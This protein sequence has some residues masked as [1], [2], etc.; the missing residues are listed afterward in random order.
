MV[1]LKDGWGY[2]RPVW[3]RVV[4]VILVVIG[5]VIC[6][7]GFWNLKM[8]GRWIV[9]CLQLAASFALLS[10]G[11]IFWGYPVCD[12]VPLPLGIGSHFSAKEAPHG[13]VEL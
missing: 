3:L 6:F 2:Y 12:S 4:G 8:S 7:L 1:L 11:I 5:C 13:G 9:A 10:L